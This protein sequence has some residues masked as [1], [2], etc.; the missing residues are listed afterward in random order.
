[1]ISLE[2]GKKLLSLAKE[3]V[4]T[5][6]FDEELKPDPA[7]LQKYSAPQGV[8]VTL[9]EH[10]QL[11]GCIGFP[12]PVYPLTEA[13]IR[14]ARAA[15]FDDPRFPPVEENEFEDLHFEISILTVPEKIVVEKPEGYTDKVEIGKDGLILRLQ[16]ASGLLLPQVPVEWKWNAKQ[17]LENLSMKAGLTKDAWQHD[18]AELLKF[19]AQ[20][21]SEEDGDIV[22]KKL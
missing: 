2:D 19:Q 5:A 9:H 22:E 12:E 10:D 11:R 18:E 6:L 17:F 4:R 13:I 7:L 16:G 14:G 8:F 15:A 20:I 1:M 21:F 3:S